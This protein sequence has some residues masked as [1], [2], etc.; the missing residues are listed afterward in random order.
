MTLNSKASEITHQFKYSKEELDRLVR[1]DLNA[2]L[3]TYI[4]ILSPVVWLLL[5][6]KLIWDGSRLDAFVWLSRD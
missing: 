3:S 4:R 2:L 6:A 5:K 1:F